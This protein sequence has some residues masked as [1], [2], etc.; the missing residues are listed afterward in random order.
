[1]IKDVFFYI[2]QK[3]N[4]NM[5]SNVNSPRNVRSYVKTFA[6]NEEDLMHI[7]VIPGKLNVKFHL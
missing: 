2:C 7:L 1:M 4:S 3:T 6:K 5:T